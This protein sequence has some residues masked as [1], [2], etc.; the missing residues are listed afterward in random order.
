MIEM[1]GVLIPLHTIQDTHKIQDTE[2][3]THEIATV[4]HKGMHNMG[5]VTS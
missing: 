3:R 4:K 5:S 2:S 1:Q